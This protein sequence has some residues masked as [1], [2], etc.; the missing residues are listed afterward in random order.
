LTNGLV[1]QLSFNVPQFAVSPM[2]LTGAWQVFEAQTG[3]VA[4]QGVTALQV[5][6]AAHFRTLLP[7]QTLSFG[8]HSRVLQAPARQL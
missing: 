7:E 2:Q 6:L 8:E 4:A 5:P 3:V 1:Q